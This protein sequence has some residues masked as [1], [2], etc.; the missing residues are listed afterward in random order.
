MINVVNG[1]TKLQCGRPSPAWVATDV[2]LGV[3]FKQR[4]EG[5]G[6]NQT[7]KVKNIAFPRQRRAD[8]NTLNGGGKH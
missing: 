8:M 6:K 2:L 3:T 4:H 7:R 5:L 1:K